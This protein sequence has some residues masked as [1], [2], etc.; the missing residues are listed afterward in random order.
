MKGIE[1]GDIKLSDGNSDKTLAGSAVAEKDLADKNVLT[2]ILKDLDKESQLRKLHLLKERLHHK[3]ELYQ[4]NLA[5]EVMKRYARRQ[6]RIYINFLFFFDFE[7]LLT[8]LV[9]QT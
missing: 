9:R 5:S 8:L 2:E 7:S 4:S 1:G 3:T 6:G